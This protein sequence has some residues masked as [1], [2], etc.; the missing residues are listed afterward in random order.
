MSDLTGHV[1]TANANSEFVWDRQL[2]ERYDLSGPRYTSYPTAPQFSNQF[3]LLELHNAF[4]ASNRACTPL[5]LYFHIPFCSR[6]CYFCACNKIVTANRKRSGPYLQR[7]FREMEM[8]A[9]LLDNFRPVKQLHWGGG[10]PTFLSDDEMR[11]LMAKTREHFHLLDNDEG[12]YSIELH[13]GDMNVETIRC[14]REI[15]FNR[16]SMGVQDFDPVVQSAVNRFN[17]LEQVTELIDAAREQGFASISMDLIYGLPHQNWQSFS[18]TLDRIIELSPDR[19]SVFN[20]AHLPH[21]FK[22]QRQINEAALPAAEEKLRMMEQSALKLLDAGY[23][24]IGMDHFAKPEDELS[25]AQQQGELQ[26]NFQGYSTHSGCDMVALGVSAISEI[27]STLSQN[28]KNIDDYYGAIDNGLLPLSQGTE[29]NQDDR[30]RGRVI[31]QLICQFELDFQEV[32][33]AFSI[34]FQ[35][36]FADELYQ[37]RAME[38]D[39]LLRISNH[40]IRIHPAGRLLIRRICMV[41][42]AYVGGERQVRFSKII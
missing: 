12:E 36:Y 13:P 35:R 9:E 6:V 39:G 38:T 2:I 25:V 22:V 4:A 5:S 37:L 41:F 21:L 8:K 20:Y 3:G 1:F 31:S 18:E 19:L 24:F 32:E 29:L 11:Q 40:G 14:L 7:L 33:Q 28:H 27:G 15:G 10:T 26:R 34:D 17:S 23:R 42:D 30:I 16:L